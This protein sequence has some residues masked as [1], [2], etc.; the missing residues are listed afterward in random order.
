MAFENLRQALTNTP[1]FLYP[2]YKDYFILDTDTS[3]TCLG[4]L[5][6]LVLSQIQDG[7]EKVIAYNSKAFS[8]TERK[9]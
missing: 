2:R 1:I 7:K 9:Y 8:R 3:N 5:P 4:F 6:V